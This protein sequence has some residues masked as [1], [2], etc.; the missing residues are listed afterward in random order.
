MD[1]QGRLLCAIT[2]L[3]LA[4][5]P[6]DVLLKNAPPS[7]GEVPAEEDWLY[8]LTWQESPAVPREPAASA[9][10]TWLIVPDKGGLGA[11]LAEQLE[12][13][14]EHC[15]PA[16]PGEVSRVLTANPVLRGVVYLRGLDRPKC[17]ENGEPKCEDLMAAQQHALGGLLEL[18]QELAARHGGPA[19]RLCIATR[20]AVSLQKD[21]S[22]DAS[23]ASL[24]GLARVVSLEH[25]ELR[26][27]RIDLDTMAANGE[28]VEALLAELHHPDREDQV[29]Y[30]GG[31]RYAAR[32][33]RHRTA[34]QSAGAPLAV[35][36]GPT[37][38]VR[39]EIPHRGLLDNVAL[40][41]LTRRPPGRGEVEIAVHATGLNFRDVLNVLGL[42]PGDPGPLGGECSGVI[43]AVGEGVVGL[44]V[45]D[46]V[47]GIA[48]GSFASYVTTP[49]ALVVKK[50]AAIGFAAAA[51]I[52]I[53]FLTAHYALNELAGVQRGDRVLIQA[54]AGGVGLAAV[55]LCRRAGA[56]IFG[57]AGSPV[58]RKYLV[59]QGLA[60]S[61]LFNSRNVEFAEG[62]RKLT[63]G[64]GVRIVLNSLA[65]DFIPKGLSLVAP[66]GHFLE[67]GK[68]DV[69]S[70]QRVASVNPQA[71]YTA[72]ALDQ[73]VVEDPARVGQMLSELMPLFESGELQPLCYK[74]FPLEDAAGALRYMAQAK[75]IGKVVVRVRNAERGVRSEA[76]TRFPGIRSDATYLITG[77]LGALG[78]KTAQWLADQGAKHLV[79]AGRRAPDQ[80]TQRVLDELQRR[81]VNIHVAQADLSQREDVRRLLAEAAS[82]MPPLKGIVH[83]AG[84]LDDGILTNLDWPRFER[85]LA[86][87][88]AAGWH[89]H[90]LTQDRP[91]DFFVLYSS[92][93]S[94]LGSPGQGNYAA[95]N[96]FLDGLAWHR[97][98]RGLSATSIN[99]GPW[100]EAGMAA[101]RGD[102][103]HRRWAAQGLTP[104]PTETGFHLLGKLIASQPT[105]AA[106]LPVNWTQWAKAFPQSVEMPLFSHVLAARATPCTTGVDRPLILAVEPSRRRERLETYL[107]EQVARVLRIS[108]E[109]L[110]VQQP[111]KAVGLD[112]L[113]AIE[114]KN[115]A[116]QNLAVEIPAAKLLEGPTIAQL[117]E[118]LAPQLGGTAAAIEAEADQSSEA[119]SLDR[120]IVHRRPQPDPRLWLFCFHFLGGGASAFAD[121]QESL[122][123][124]IEVCPVQLPGREERLQEP[125]VENMQSLVATLS[126]ELM[127]LLDRPFALY[128]H[129]MG[130]LIA[131]ALARQLRRRNLLPRHLFVG[132]YFAPH[133]PSP[134]VMREDLHAVD[135]NSAVQ[136]MLDAPQAV[137]DNEEFMQAL[138]PTVQADSRLVGSYLHVEEPPLECPITAFGGL[139]DEEVSADDL[140]QWQQHTSA[141]FR[142]ELLP[143]KHLFLF[144]D[145]EPLLAAIRRELE[146]ALLPEMSHSAP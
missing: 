28:E 64:Q 15:L 79:L 22:V 145:R 26:P 42:Y 69:W 62:I 8:E 14:G 133:A 27:L 118:L 53:T 117:A 9:S 138:L 12:L 132:G 137:L 89:L 128:G 25:A 65:G 11:A 125:A 70:H 60:E 1:S 78:L 92:M 54:A 31:T 82:S 16:E 75:H 50:P 121:W 144:S 66:G 95:A 17:P 5:A 38:D 90:Q 45:G 85:V 46:E 124:E 111:L 106:V 80:Q 115:L 146:A 24:W 55:Q 86:P 94:L 4:R 10:G 76:A 23:A 134:F 7:V 6:R 126:Q 97:R 61:H 47:L 127:P 68:A 57:T 35:S 34:P 102:A 105:Q 99:W 73:M 110:D 84:V 88:A 122:G 107:R 123:E 83:A 13:R 74:E 93:A 140:A 56:E 71:K 51:T 96:A 58:K 135:L 109:Q 44:Q 143:G 87:K 141:E 72:I 142:L 77:G 113:M 19:T 108:A 30:R 131:F 49:A 20:G 43:S 59:E 32:L 21:A 37:P 139:R 3:A 119:S 103:D 2:G 112:S 104:I 67:I 63:G 52:P 136:R 48:A 120:W 40:R 81:G 41:P 39:L 114:L 36:H 98:S 116:E 100:A 101:A 29:A 91:L 130:A 129:S 18:V 33:S